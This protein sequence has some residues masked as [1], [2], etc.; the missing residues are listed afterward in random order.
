MSIERSLPAPVGSDGEGRKDSGGEVDVT[1]LLTDLGH[2]VDV[3]ESD[4]CSWW[5]VVVV[6]KCS[7]SWYFPRARQPSVCVCVCVNG[8]GV[9]EYASIFHHLT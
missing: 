1:S 4:L 7:S 5:L 6:D 2:G 3:V 8:G 9:C